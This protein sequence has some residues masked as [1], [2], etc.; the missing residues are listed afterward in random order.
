MRHVSAAVGSTKSE[1]QASR[2]F[3]CF[4][5]VQTLCSLCLCG[6][7]SQRI[8]NHR[9]TENTEVAQRRSPSELRA[10]EQLLSKRTLLTHEFPQYLALFPRHNACEAVAQIC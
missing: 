3:N 6:G 9:D 8:L 1:T 2:K 10:G 7:S 4:F 5:S